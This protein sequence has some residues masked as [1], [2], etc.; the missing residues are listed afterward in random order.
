M[1]RTIALRLAQSA[2]RSLTP[3]DRRTFDFGASTC[4]FEV[5]ESGVQQLLLCRG[6]HVR[7]VYE[8]VTPDDGSVTTPPHESWRRDAVATEHAHWERFRGSG[9]R[10]LVVDQNIP[11]EW[12]VA[13]RRGVAWKTELPGLA[14]SSP[15]VWGTT[16]WR[17]QQLR[18]GYFWPGL[19]THS[20]RLGVSEW[21][22]HRSLRLPMFADSAHPECC[23]PNLAIGPRQQSKWTITLLS[24]A[25]NKVVN[26]C[27]EMRTIHELESAVGAPPVAG[28][29]VC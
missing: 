7:S 27:Q 19:V 26:G 13:S 11:D 17:R 9:G 23:H 2:L 15:I 18:V 4:R 21:L 28:G 12:D 1:E 5:A 24:I 16:A 6:K 10:G 22:V 3:R 20:W 25:V 8:H 29:R 14:H